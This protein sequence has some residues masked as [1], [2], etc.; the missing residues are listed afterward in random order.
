MESGNKSLIVKNNTLP[1]TFLHIK[2]LKWYIVEKYLVEKESQN[3]GEDE[4]EQKYN[5][6]NVWNTIKKST[7]LL[8]LKT[9]I[10]N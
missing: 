5:D 1:S 3:K 6:M 2:F 7:V 9:L 4:Y 10:E 8:L